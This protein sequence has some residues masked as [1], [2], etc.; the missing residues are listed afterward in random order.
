MFCAY[1]TLRRKI[2]YDQLGAIN[3][4]GCLASYVDYKGKFDLVILYEDLCKD[5]HAEAEALF[6]VLGV[7]KAHIS[8]AVSALQDGDS[9]KGTFAGHWGKRRK[10]EDRAGVEHVLSLADIGVSLEM[11]E[12]EFRRLV[13]ARK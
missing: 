5:P 10:V 2:S 3:Y 8:S 7:E 13:D 9:E 4:V 1:S 6:N 12:E 11:S